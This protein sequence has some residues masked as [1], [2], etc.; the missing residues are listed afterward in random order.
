MRLVEGREQPAPLLSRY[1][2]LHLCSAAVQSCKLLFVHPLLNSRC[3]ILCACK[4]SVPAIDPAS[5]VRNRP[6]PLRPSSPSALG[7]GSNIGP[8]SPLEHFRHAPLQYPRIPGLAHLPP[9]M[10]GRLRLAASAW[11]GSECVRYGRSMTK[12]GDIQVSQCA[13]SV[14]C[15]SALRTESFR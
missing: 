3:P 7:T 4:P 11:D 14:S 13:G 1:W 2:R 8:F 12:I 5:S 10:N 9:C 6:A 15:P